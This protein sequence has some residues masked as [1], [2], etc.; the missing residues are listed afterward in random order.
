MDG[1]MGYSPQVVI[2]FIIL[3]V[4]VAFLVYRNYGSQDETGV[5][6]VDENEKHEES[7]EQFDEY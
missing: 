5:I 6:H 7:G 3:A 2:L 4:V 1:F